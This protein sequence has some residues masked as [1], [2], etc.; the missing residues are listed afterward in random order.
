MLRSQS[1]GQMWMGGLYAYDAVRCFLGCPPAWMCYCIYNGKKELCS[2]SCVCTLHVLD[3]RAHT[4][5]EAATCWQAHTC[6]CHC[7]DNG[8]RKN[9]H[10]STSDTSMQNTSHNVPHLHEILAGCRTS[11]NQTRTVVCRSSQGEMTEVIISLM[12]P[13]TLG[14]RGLSP[15]P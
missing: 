10:G 6:F 11:S 4:G 5:L 15:K 3:P 9:N 13:S 2:G 8:K 1:A 14:R 12:G 7:V